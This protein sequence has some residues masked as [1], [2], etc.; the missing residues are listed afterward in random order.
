MRTRWSLSP[1]HE[2]WLGSHI[3][4][5]S[6]RVAKAVLAL[7]DFYVKN[8]GEKTPWGRI[9]N[10]E[11]A[12]LSYFHPLNV[13]RLKAVLKETARFLRD[14]DFTEIW[15]FGSGAGAVHM[16]LEEQKQFLPKPLY[17]V[18]ADALARGLHQKWCSELKPRWSAEWR[19]GPT[20]S[21]GALAVFS[22]SYLEMSGLNPP[23]KK[24]DH[25]L[26]LEP[27]FQ[28][29]GRD[30]MKARQDWLEQG[31]TMLAPCPHQ[32]PCPLLTH[33]P[34]DWCHHRIHIERP[35]CLE[36]LER[37]LPMEN[38]SL[39]YSYLLMTRSASAA[40]AAI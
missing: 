20:P 12:Y 11:M 25:V 33:S 8:H 17:C 6:E 19:S 7:S 39:T 36:K 2:E 21:Q 37:H 18:E 40:A 22:Y 15:D 29:T 4:P 16:A 5:S 9:E 24:F 38:R 1:Q 31:W 28:D 27:S 10:S 14:S 30:L 3:G 32:K 13:L 23:L 35:T 34:R 26:I